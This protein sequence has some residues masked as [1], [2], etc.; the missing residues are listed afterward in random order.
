[1]NL[2]KCRT[3]FMSIKNRTKLSEQKAYNLKGSYGRRMGWGGQQN[4]LTK[5]KNHKTTSE[6]V[7]KS[8]SKM[9]SI[10]R[11][12]SQQLWAKINGIIVLLPLTKKT[13]M[14]KLFINLSHSQILVL[15]NNN[16][17]RTYS[18]HPIRILLSMMGQS[19][20]IICQT[21]GLRFKSNKWSAALPLMVNRASLTEAKSC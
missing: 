2:D 6:M 7:I 5:C 19:F 16:L 12:G 20:I 11:Q 17:I 1:M 8:Q 4:R 9:V 18:L 3:C 10:C 13:Q 21:L 14:L 15:S